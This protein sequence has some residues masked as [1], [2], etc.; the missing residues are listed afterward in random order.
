MVLWPGPLLPT[1]HP[2]CQVVTPP[3]TP[4]RSH[5]SLKLCSGPAYLCC[6]PGVPLSTLAGVP[7][8]RQ[9]PPGAGDLPGAEV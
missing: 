6:T 9:V 2:L 4:P 7:S 1:T 8:T 3:N 5:L